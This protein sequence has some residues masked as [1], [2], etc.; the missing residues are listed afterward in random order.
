MKPNAEFVTLA[1]L[2]MHVF[3]DFHL[4]GI[5]ANMKQKEWWLNLKEYKV[6]YENDYI[7]ALISHSISWSFCVMLPI[8]W[9]LG[10][11]ITPLFTTMF[12]FNVVIH[13]IIDDLKANKLK[14]NLAVDQTIHIM[15]LF[16]T[17][18]MLIY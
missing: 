7:V 14:I 17:Y 10:F 13:A 15:Q 4:Q 18:I 9:Y 11:V 8:A 12:I 5:L 1:M 3:D 16:F 2:F 6:M